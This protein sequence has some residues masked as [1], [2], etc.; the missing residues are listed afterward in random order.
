MSRSPFVRRA[1]WVGPSTL[2]RSTA[3]YQAKKMMGDANSLSSKENRAPMSTFC[4]SCG[5]HHRSDTLCT[6]MTKAVPLPMSVLLVPSNI[7][8]KGPPSQFPQGTQSGAPRSNQGGTPLAEWKPGTGSDPRAQPGGGDNTGA[9]T[10]PGKGQAPQPEKKS[11]KMINSPVKSGTG[12]GSTGGNP[13]HDPKTGRF[14]SKKG[15]GGDES[16]GGKAPMPGSD[17][18]K[19]PGQIDRDA[20]MSQVDRQNQQSSDARQR[21]AGEG[22]S[23]DDQD[24]AGWEAW[25]GSSMKDQQ[26][27]AAQAKQG[28]PKAAEHVPTA[29]GQ[30][31]SS[32]GSG[33]G[34]SSPGGGQPGQGGGQPGQGGGGYPPA[35]PRAPMAPRGVPMGQQTNKPLPVGQGYAIG[36]AQ[37][38]GMGTPGGVASA[39]GRHLGQGTHFILNAPQRAQQQMARQRALAQSSQH[40]A[41]Q[42]ANHAAQM[43]NWTRTYGQG[44]PQAGQNMRPGFQQPQGY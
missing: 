37:G 21:V 44:S 38:A 14:A 3:A 42:R 4:P 15:G 32:G 8:R 29:P 30:G 13:M 36:H 27:Q 10:L 26:A 20:M 25:S 31:S 28:G 1:S 2:R 7:L 41:Q 17:K 24:R 35:P 9:Q 5:N 16:G 11:D 12:K 6:R 19:S 34:G 18:P 43:A 22:G 40:Y 23:Q 33:A 39:A